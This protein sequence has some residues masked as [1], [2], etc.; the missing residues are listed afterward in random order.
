MA[1][2]QVAR[3]LT[4]ALRV[5]GFGRHRYTGDRQHWGEAAAQIV[6]EI[7]IQL[8]HQLEVGRVYSELRISSAL[9]RRLAATLVEL[10]DQVDAAELSDDDAPEV[11]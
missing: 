5:V 6:L 2:F 10:A 9:A 8:G 4:D 1:R 3:D 7:G 11:R